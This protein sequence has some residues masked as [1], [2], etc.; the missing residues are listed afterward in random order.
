MKPKDVN[1]FIIFFSPFRSIF[2][3]FGSFFYGKTKSLKLTKIHTC[4]LTRLDKFST[5]TRYSVR[6][7]GPY[8]DE[9]LE[10]LYLV[11]SIVSFY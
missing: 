2:H 9:D 10:F 1:R 11:Y 7:G 8:L 4:Q 6:N 3:F 5:T